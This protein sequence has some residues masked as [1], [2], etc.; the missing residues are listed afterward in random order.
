MGDITA[1]DKSMKSPSKK[2]YIIQSQYI[3]YNGKLSWDTEANM[4]GY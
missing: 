2:P 3:P 4:K 1:D